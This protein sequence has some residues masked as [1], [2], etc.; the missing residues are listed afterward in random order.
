[1][2][3]VHVLWSMALL[4]TSVLLT[5]LLLQLL[6]LALLFLLPEWLETMS[7]ALL[8]VQQ[9]RTYGIKVFRKRYITGNNLLKDMNFQKK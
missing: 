3:E 7:S 8:S 1:M 6:C 2:L 4:K 9:N 5:A